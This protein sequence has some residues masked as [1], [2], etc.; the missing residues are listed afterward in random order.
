MVKAPVGARVKVKVVKLKGLS[1][2]QH[3]SLFGADWLNAVV[4]A[5]VLE[6]KGRSRII[7]FDDANLVNRTLGASLMLEISTPVVPVAV[8]HA[9]PPPA[10]AAVGNDDNFPPSG[11]ESDDDVSFGDSDQEE[12]LEDDPNVPNDVALGGAGES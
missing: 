7:R 10:M 11:T 12:E 6:V 1:T 4:I 5:T 9:V 8:A 3:V 2:E